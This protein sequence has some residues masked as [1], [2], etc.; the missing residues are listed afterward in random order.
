[1]GPGRDFYLLLVLP[2]QGA[3]AGGEMPI[4]LLCS[5]HRG[6]QKKERG[7]TSH[8]D[9]HKTGLVCRAQLPLGSF[10]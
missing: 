7:A 3:S 5:L 2:R 9:F 6:E 1:M 8:L 4:L 10:T